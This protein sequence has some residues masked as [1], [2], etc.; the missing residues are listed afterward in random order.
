[1]PTSHSEQQFDCLLLLNALCNYVQAQ[2]LAERDCRKN[3]RGDVRSGFQ[4]SNESLV[5]LQAI[6]LNFFK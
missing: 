4:L 1:M 5:D 3:D 6:E 2:R